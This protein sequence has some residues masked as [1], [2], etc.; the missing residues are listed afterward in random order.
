MY[1]G[2]EKRRGM[3]IKG[4]SEEERGEEGRDSNYDCDWR[5]DDGN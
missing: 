1:R 2:G 3:K 4:E 5:R